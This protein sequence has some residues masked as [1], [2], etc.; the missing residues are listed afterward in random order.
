MALGCLVSG[1][2]LVRRPSLLEW[3][4]VDL[5]L[6]S[7]AVVLPHVLRG[8]ADAPCSGPCFNALGTVTG[9]QDDYQLERGSCGPVWMVERSACCFP[10]NGSTI[11]VK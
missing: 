11:N 9:A 8:Q 4:N 2:D 10:Q 6:G 3:Q 7:R 1:K 5:R